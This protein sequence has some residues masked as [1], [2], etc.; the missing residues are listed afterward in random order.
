[1]KGSYGH[2]VDEGITVGLVQGCPISRPSLTDPEA[3]RTTRTRTLK[4]PE[5]EFAFGHRERTS[6]MLRRF[7]RVSVFRISTPAR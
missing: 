5:G 1:V 3:G 6:I 2:R 4:L 7:E